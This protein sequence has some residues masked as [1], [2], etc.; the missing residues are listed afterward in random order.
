MLTTSLGE[1]SGSP[2]PLMPPPGGSHDP[3]LH[4]RRLVPP[5]PIRVAPEAILIGDEADLVMSRAAWL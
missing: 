1:L 4:G 3:Y 2:E 5:P